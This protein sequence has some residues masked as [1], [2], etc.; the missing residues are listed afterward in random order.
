MAKPP[1]PAP[2]ES[3]PPAPMAK[4]RPH[5]PNHPP[6]RR[7]RP[8]RHHPIRPLRPAS[9]R[10]RPARNPPLRT[11]TQ[12]TPHQ[13]ERRRPP[14]RRRRITPRLRP[15]LP[16]D[17]FAQH[18]Q[19]ALRHDPERNPLPK[20]RPNQIQPMA[21]QTSHDESRQQRPR[22]THRRQTYRIS[23]GRLPP[24]SIRPPAFDPTRRPIPAG[25]SPQRKIHQPPKRPSFESA[26][27][28]WLARRRLHVG[29]KNLRRHRRPDRPARPGHRGRH[30]SSPRRRRT[31][32]TPLA[33]TGLR[34][35]L[36]LATGS[37]GQ[38]LVPDHPHLPPKGPRRLGGG[39]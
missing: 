14:D 10:P 20:R 4:P 35:R 21:S 24:P 9:R 7:V 28:S 37:R 2:Y 18:L 17:E 5:R 13:P 38:S 22:Q 29:T 1:Q 39:D 6:P 27:A 26:P 31:R 3:L 11:R 12:R 8:R 32:Q 25:A 36:A 34:P 23:L 16:T 19:H 15:A 33:T 30:L